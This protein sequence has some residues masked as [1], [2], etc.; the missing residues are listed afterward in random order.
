MLKRRLAII[1]S[2]LVFFMGAASSAQAV[3][4][5]ISADAIKGESSSR[6]YV[7]KIEVNSFNLEIKTSP[8][9]GGSGGGRASSKA[10]F[11]AFKVTKVIDQ[12]S[13][14][15][16]TSLV[17][18]K[19]IKS[20]V[21]DFVR[22][23]GAGRAD[24][25]ASAFVYLRYTFS[26]V[27]ASEYSIIVDKEDGERGLETIGFVYSKISIDYTFQDV[28]GKRVSG[29]KFGFDVSANRLL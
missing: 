8:V 23:D 9:A 25:A 1:I 28:T 18:G 12:S 7:D 21:V 4:I 6:N 2:L 3:D 5:F 19:T 15:I 11:P 16:L 22:A 27:I 20:F 10:S 14:P 29:P 26:D 24:G 13:N 17:T